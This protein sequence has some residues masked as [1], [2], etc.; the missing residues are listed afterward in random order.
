M[1]T[2]SRRHA[3]VPA[4]YDWQRRGLL[5]WA[6]LEHY[7]EDDDFRRDLRTLALPGGDNRDRV[8]EIAARYGLDRLMADEHHLDGLSLLG[9]WVH[10]SRQSPG[11]DLEL[12]SVAGFGGAVAQLAVEDRIAW[13]PVRESRPDA[14]D[15]IVAQ[16]EALL[17]RGEAE[18]IKHGHL[19]LDTAPRLKDHVTWTYLRLRG[20]TYTAIAE[21]A[22]LEGGVHH[23]AR[24]VA[25]AVRGMAEQI[26]LTL[27]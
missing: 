27:P 10:W 15:R 14:R 19:T 22:S 8:A 17:A 18:A 4:L 25:I 5:R 9:E 20:Q 21:R 1:S 7:D 12:C 3:R 6:L 24:G 23:Q 16:V 26:G 2:N 13:D 11:S